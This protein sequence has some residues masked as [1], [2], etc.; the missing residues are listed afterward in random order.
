MDFLDQSGARAGSVTFPE[1]ITSG[2]VVRGERERELEQ[3]ISHLKQETDAL[4]KRLLEQQQQAGEERDTVEQ[5]KQTVAE[6]Q[7]KETQNF[8]LHRIHPDARKSFLESKEFREEF[9]SPNPRPAFVMA[10][11]LRRSTELMLKSRRPKLFAEFIT[12]LCTTLGNLVLMNH[13]VFDKFTGDGILAFFPEFY[14][15]TDAGYYAM[16][17]ADACHR[18]FAEHYRAHYS[19]FH[20]VIKDVGL[21]IGVDYGEIH[22]IN[23]GQELA[24]VGT[25]VVY[26]CRMAGTSARTTLVNQQAYEPLHEKYSL[27]C[28]F[29]E[30]EIDVK[31]EGAHL[32]YHAHLS[33]NSSYTPTQPAWLKYSKEVEAR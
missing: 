27:Y 10:V 11:D 15:G 33:Q 9:L 13:G 32:G 29:T 18:V 28:S 25:P 17:V 12:G 8:I 7:E 16:T 30:G 21:G 26:A 4:Q 2:P 19:S 14:S 6:L 1:L 22:L 31:H 23:I 5:L 20:T 3:Q 24:I